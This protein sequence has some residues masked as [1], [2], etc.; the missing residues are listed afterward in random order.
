MRNFDPWFG[1]EIKSTDVVW[2]LELPQEEMPANGRMGAFRTPLCAF[3]V[4]PIPAWVGPIK[5]LCGNLHN[6][7]GLAKASA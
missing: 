2:T 6:C 4:N 1:T 5:Y 3:K 7:S